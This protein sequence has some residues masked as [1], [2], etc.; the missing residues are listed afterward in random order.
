VQGIR[1][2][3]LLIIRFGVQLRDVFKILSNAPLTYRELSVEENVSLLFLIKAVI[4]FI[5]FCFVKILKHDGEL[6]NII[7]KF[8]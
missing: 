6:V 4:H 1:D 5:F 3:L 2:S 7:D 8:F